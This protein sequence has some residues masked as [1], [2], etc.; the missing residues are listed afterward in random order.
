MEYRRLG[1]TEIEVSAVAFGGAP[2]GLTNYLDRW[3]PDDPQDEAQAIQAIHTALDA[4]I[5][6]IDTAASYG[7]GRSE[8][9]VG[10]AIA[11]AGDAGKRAVLAT[12]VSKRDRAGIFASA[13]RSLRHLGAE[14]ID[15]FQFHGSRWTDEDAS[16]VLDGE[17]LPAFQELKAQ[18]KI[19]YLGFTAEIG[20]PGVYRLIRSDAFDVM[21]IAYNVL[22]QDA[23]NL[24]VKAGPIVEAKERGMGVVTMRSLSSGIFQKLLRQHLPGLPAEADLHAFALN[25][26]LS[27]RYADSAI[28]GMR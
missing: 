5:T 1:S 20:S 21:Q 26:V 15:V 9:I 24:M 16:A 19:R 25:F 12:K 11:S 23:C 22:Y 6:Y 3:N 14:T 8:Q 13:E 2:I 28:V 4:G 10:K 27:N 7:D 18:G 17:G